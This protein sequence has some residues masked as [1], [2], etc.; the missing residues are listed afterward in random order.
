MLENV[1]KRF[2]NLPSLRIDNLIMYVLN[3]RISGALQRRGIV[4]AAGNLSVSRR[5]KPRF[6]KAANTFETLVSV[7][8]FGWSG[9]S[10]VIDLLREYSGIT[11]KYAGTADVG[12]MQPEPKCFEFELARAAGGVF[13]LEHAFLT[14]NFFE[15]DAAVRVF[16]V[17][18]ERMYLDNS[19]FFGEEFVDLTSRFLSSLIIARAEN[20][21][22]GFDYCHHLRVLGNCAVNR[23]LG[24]P[25]DPAKDYIFYLRDISVKEY[26]TIAREYLGSVLR[27][28][29]SEKL[30][31]LDQATSDDCFDV[32][33][34]QDY[35]GPIKT[36]FVWRDP[37]EVYA[38]SQMYANHESFFPKDPH[39]FVSWYGSV[40]RRA[41]SVNHGMWLTVRF[42]DLLYSYDSE[43]KRIEDFLGVSPNNHIRKF[44]TFVPQQSIV[45]SIGHWRRYP[46]QKAMSVIRNELR[47]FCYVPPEKDA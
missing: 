14:H 28:I 29:N 22:G 19:S 11:T 7:G 47:E 46:D 4:D 27:Y 18:A 8:G 26:R 43:V 33:R 25:E 16:S 9:S 23:F 2:K 37:S 34:Y 41:L 24:H 44:T 42:E 13:N 36:V 3:K 38:A 32:S 21:G 12:S 30:L 35:F 45:R 17:L 20:K 39:E 31:V 40:L 6:V 15:R 5:T 1:V 10:A